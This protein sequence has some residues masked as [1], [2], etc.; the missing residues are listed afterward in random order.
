MTYVAWAARSEYRLTD[1]STVVGR[2]NYANAELVEVR[3][4]AGDF[5]SLKRVDI[6]HTHRIA[7]I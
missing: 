7:K 1:G 6:I 2:A 5:I 4:D 3:T